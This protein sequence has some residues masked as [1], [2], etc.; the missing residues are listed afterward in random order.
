MVGIAALT[1]SRVARMIKI[2]DQAC[3]RTEL[4]Q[5]R[6]VLTAGKKVDLYPS[7]K[8]GRRCR[9]TSGSLK[10]LEGVVTTRRNNGRIFL[11]IHAIGQSAIVDVGCLEPID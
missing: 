9:V 10:G 4:E 5:L 2:N 7:I 3:I 6:R 11:S 1:T 8:T